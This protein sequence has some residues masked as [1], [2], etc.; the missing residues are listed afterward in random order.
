M[1]VHEIIHPLIQHKLGLMREKDIST[2]GFRTLAS[3]VGT[4]LTYEA[5]KDLALE[6]TVIPGWNGDIKVERLKGKKN[7]SRSYSACRSGYAG[8]RC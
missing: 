8:W 2:K 1:S 7:N 5:T 4:L 6:E 3:E